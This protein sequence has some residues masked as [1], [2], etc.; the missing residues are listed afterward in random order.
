MGSHWVL[1]SPLTGE[2]IYRLCAPM[3]KLPLLEVP[4]PPRHV[5][6]NMV[7]ADSMEQAA[8]KE[9]PTIAKTGETIKSG[10][11]YQTAHIQA[12]HR[13]L[14]IRVGDVMLDLRPICRRAHIDCGV[15]AAGRC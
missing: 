3:R 7:G 11:A 6:L 13:N 14:R 9:T 15:L 12:C 2:E 1:S 10:A 8:D 5:Y 4:Q